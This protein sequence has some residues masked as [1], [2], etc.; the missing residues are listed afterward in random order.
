[1]SRRF[2]V[3]LVGPYRRGDTLRPG[4]GPWHKGVLPRRGGAV[5]PGPA[6]GREQVAGST[7]SNNYWSST[8]YENNPNN[9]WN[10]D[11]NDGNVNANDKN[12]DNHV[13]AVRGGSCRRP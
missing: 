7:A 13:R 4:D 8:T 2:P 3:R 12:N 9:A 11:F 6:A 10:V 5:R 1:M